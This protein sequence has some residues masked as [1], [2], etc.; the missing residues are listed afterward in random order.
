MNDKR[1]ASPGIPGTRWC[2]AGDTAS[3]F[4]GAAFVSMDKS[5]FK[6]RC[7][8]V[9]YGK[10]GFFRSAGVIGA[11]NAESYRRWRDDQNRCPVF[12]CIPPATRRKWKVRDL[13]LVSIWRE[14][15]QETASTED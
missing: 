11:V 10:D 6:P 12:R 5:L 7:L 15:L 2:C 13:D 14:E 3:S 9:T 1:F 4:L 8:N